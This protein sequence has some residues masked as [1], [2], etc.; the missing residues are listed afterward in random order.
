MEDP[1]NPLQTIQTQKPLTNS[2]ILN[3]C[4]ICVEP[5]NKRNRMTV[6]CP[7]CEYTACRSCYHT[8]LLNETAPRC[9]NPDC[10][11]EWTLH[12]I[13]NAFTNTFLNT[14][15]KTHRED[16]LF[17]QEVALLPATQPLVEQEIQRENL[18]TQI[19]VINREIELLRRQ[20]DVLW[21]EYS[22]VGRVVTVERGVATTTPRAEFVRNCPAP[23]CRGFLSTQWKCGICSKWTCPTCH[24]LKGEDRNAEHTCNPANVATAEL[25]AQDTRHCPKCATPIFKIDGCNQ[26]WC[27]QC[28]TGFCWRT[29]RVES[30]VHNPHYFEWLRRTRVGGQPERAE[31]DFQCGGELTHR[32]SGEIERLLFSKTTQPVERTNLSILRHN[33]TKYMS[34]I[35]KY[36]H[37]NTHIA[38]DKLI[39]VIRSIIHVN[40]VDRGR[41]TPYGIRD[42]QDLR[43]LYLRNKLSVERFKVLVQQRHKKTH[44][45]REI[46]NVIDVVVN[47]VTDIVYRFRDYLTNSPQTEC[48][49]EMLEEIDHIRE[50]ANECLVDIS[51]TYGSVLLRF[52]ENMRLVSGKD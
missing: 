23:D 22:N 36:Q 20:T 47:T 27:T 26:M 5:F 33:D 18:R 13:R 52:N 25:L 8:Y 30:N 17:Q 12:F 21:R 41:Y 16:V 34:E 9:M 1:P 38:F 3:E 43:I 7:Y 2:F 50:Y 46:R 40:V 45:H 39:V 6:K 19:S 14:D 32:T 42:N 51:H 31:G 49:I 10:G 37:P 35:T 24:E 28:H 11:K 15:L 48:N 29:G 4:N 44:K